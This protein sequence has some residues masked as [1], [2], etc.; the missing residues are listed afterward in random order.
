MNTQQL[1]TD[2]A[3]AMA[4][5]QPLADDAFAKRDADFEARQAAAQASLTLAAARRADA[6][7]E[8]GEPSAE[9]VAAGEALTLAQDAHTIARNA[10]VAARTAA[11]EARAAVNGPSLALQARR[12]QLEAIASPS[13]AETAELAAIVAALGA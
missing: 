12:A 10:L 3:A 4:I 6:H 2:L 1:I 8:L 9:T 11:N 5:W 13:D 7:R